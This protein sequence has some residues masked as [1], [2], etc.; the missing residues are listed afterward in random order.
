MA[1][2][3][4]VD[5]YVMRGGGINGRMDRN[6]NK[7]SKSVVDGNYR[8]VAGILGTLTL[9]FACFAWQG[10]A[11][12]AFKLGAKVCQEC[13]EAEFGVWEGTQHFKSFREIRR[14]PE[15]KKLAEAVGGNKDMRKNDTCKICHFSLVQKDESSTPKPTSGPSCESCHGAASEWFEIHNNYGGKDVKRETET[16]EHKAERKANATAAGMIWPTDR[17]GIAKNCMNCHGLA[18]PDLGAEDLATMLA[19]GHPLKAEFELVLYSQG[20]RAPPLL[21][22]RCDC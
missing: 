3:A 7:L 21:S 16:P 22:A 5:P 8:R 18:H 19:S 10:V 4:D 20:F 6:M 11:E 13:H 12:A 17:Y 2:P 14:K 9:A 15:A 1:M